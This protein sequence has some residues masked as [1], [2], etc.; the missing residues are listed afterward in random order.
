[1]TMP[2]CVTE[3]EKLPWTQR[4]GRYRRHFRLLCCE[5]H[6]FDQSAACVQ[7]ERSEPAE[8]THMPALYAALIR[9]RRVLWGVGARKQPVNMWS[10]TSLSSWVLGF[11]IVVNRII[12]Q[13]VLQ[14]TAQMSRYT[15]EAVA[16]IQI[17]DLSRTLTVFL[18][19][20]SVHPSPR[21]CLR[22]LEFCLM[23]LQICFSFHVLHKTNFTVCPLVSQWS[24]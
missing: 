2:L 24:H 7:H 5:E 14:W 13:N 22:Q 12:I 15:C 21:L 23:F 3:S 16:K 17:T 9:G 4:K 18:G 20:F 8:P 11:V 1:M 6:S 10:H 19:N